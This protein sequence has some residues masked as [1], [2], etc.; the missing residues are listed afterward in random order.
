MQC[1]KS[2]GEESNSCI[3]TP[4]LDWES[5]YTQGGFLEELMPQKDMDFLTPAEVEDAP[6]REGK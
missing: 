2:H 6:G 3:L 1:N 5:E 4:N